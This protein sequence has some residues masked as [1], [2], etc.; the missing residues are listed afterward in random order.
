M[1]EYVDVYTDRQGHH[2]GITTCTSAAGPVDP[3]LPRLRS[4]AKD[5]GGP[6]H[7]AQAAA[8]AC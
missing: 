4:E 3:R 8:S 5:G 1:G 7:M 6:R 2:L